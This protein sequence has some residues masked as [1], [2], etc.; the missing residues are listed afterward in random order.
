MSN[1][2]ILTCGIAAFA[3]AGNAFAKKQQR[4]ASHQRRA[5][6]GAVLRQILID[7]QV[8]QRLH[9]IASIDPELAAGFD[10]AFSAAYRGGD[11]ATIATVISYLAAS[12]GMINLDQSL[13]SNVEPYHHD[14]VVD[15]VDVDDDTSSD[16]IGDDT[17]LSLAFKRAN[18]RG[19]VV[20]F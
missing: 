1:A 3:I 20:T 10:N 17:A 12:E 8:Q 2:V 9:H 4:K 14:D 16:A 15:H 18:S 5:E 11:V 19:N 6:I 13:R 7:N